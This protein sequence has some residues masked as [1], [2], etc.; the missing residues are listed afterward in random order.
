MKS[1]SSQKTSVPSRLWAGCQIG[2]LHCPVA[3]S[4]GASW[5]VF[6]RVLLML[7][8]ARSCLLWLLRGIFKNF[9]NPLTS[10]IDINY[11]WSI[12]ITE[13]SKGYKSRTPS[14]PPPSRLNIYYPIIVLILCNFVLFTAR[15]CETFCLASSNVDSFLRLLLGTDLESENMLCKKFA[16][17][18]S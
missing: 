12:Y 13:M 18:V 3:P 4:K 8:C 1:W 10:Q 5:P 17:V 6:L 2:P 7:W 15:H 9:M 14:P 16:N 11:G